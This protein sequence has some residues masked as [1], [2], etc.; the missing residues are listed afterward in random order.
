MDFRRWLT[1]AEQTGRH[2]I[3]LAA[4]AEARQ[5]AMLR[6]IGSHQPYDAHRCELIK[7]E[8]RW[9]SGNRP[10][11]RLWPGVFDL[12]ANSTMD[13]PFR[14]LKLPYGCFSISLSDEGRQIATPAG[15]VRSLLVTKTHV[16]DSKG[17][18]D[19]LFVFGQCVDANCKFD[20]SHFG[21]VSLFWDEGDNIERQLLS[22]KSVN[23]ASWP[24]EASR[25]ILRLSIA[26]SFLAA[27]GDRLVS[28]H[29][30]AA[31]LVDYIESQRR[32]DAERQRAIEERAV[33]RRRQVG[34]EVGRDEVVRPLFGSPGTDNVTGEHL[35]HSHVRRG[36]FRRVGEERVV[37]VRPTIVRPDLPADPRASRYE[38]AAA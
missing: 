11:F 16:K 38:V 31:D 24:I 9:M 6:S 1:V 37:F 12:L 21:I 27:G 33:R 2:H 8:S 26:V 14:F 13:L 36:H 4:D 28:P 15:N 20:N 22:A 17:E 25:A 35:S 5:R 10:Y 34:Y 18:R 32:G 30:L 29:V 3:D 7:A 19:M 23:R